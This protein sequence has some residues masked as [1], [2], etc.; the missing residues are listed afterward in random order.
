MQRVLIFMSIS[1]GT[2]STCFL[3]Y[4]LTNSTE[5]NRHV[6][7]SR[8]IKISVCM[9]SAIYSLYIM[10]SNSFKIIYS[11][12][13]KQ[14]TTLFNNMNILKLR[15]LWYESIPHLS[16]RGFLFLKFFRCLLFS[17]HFLQKPDKP[18]HWVRHL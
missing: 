6:I 15:I 1:L 13:E 8:S 2:S 17:L 3:F 11:F 18:L 4:G 10:P 14:Y 9:R 5:I 16:V 12:P 7:P